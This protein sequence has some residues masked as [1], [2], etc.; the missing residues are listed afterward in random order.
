MTGLNQEREELRQGKERAE[1]EARRCEVELEEL[2]AKAVGVEGEWKA[3]W[4]QSRELCTLIKAE[5]DRA[6]GEQQQLLAEHRR[7]EQ[8]LTATLERLEAAA[9]K[10]KERALYALKEADERRLREVAVERKK[11]AADLALAANEKAELNRSLSKEVAEFKRAASQS[12]HGLIAAE[13]K[14]AQLAANE[15]RLVQEKLKSERRLKELT[16]ALA[17]RERELAANT[18]AVSTAMTKT[19][20][21]PL[22]ASVAAAE[23]GVG[24]G[25]GGAGGCARVRCGA[26][27]GGD[28]GPARGAAV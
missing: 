9:V 1:G 17:D 4:E 24:C 23:W 15:V 16:Q 2:R 26:R 22:Q 7:E 5:A 20:V 8:R 12:N 11:S 25:A 19:Q 3:K 28:A 14:L 18:A 13:A 6:Q 27:V 10:E 21:A